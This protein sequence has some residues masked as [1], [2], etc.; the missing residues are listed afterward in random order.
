M[1][2]HEEFLNSERSAMAVVEAAK[3]KKGITSS[4]L[5][6]N[7]DIS[8]PAAS[9]ILNNLEDKGFLREAERNKAKFYTVNYKGIIEYAIKQL[10]EYSDVESLD[11]SR[12]FALLNDIYNYILENSGE[13][14]SLYDLL[15]PSAMIQLDQRLEKK[16]EQVK[17]DTA[18]TE[19]ELEKKDRRIEKLS[20]EEEKKKVIEDEREKL[21][22]ELE[23]LK[24][25]KEDMEKLK[26]AVEDY[27][28]IKDS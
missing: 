21:R 10:E 15:F 20:Q 27:L 3:A 7:H 25:E 19:E 6:A 16:I 13:G 4:Q 8:Q 17:E 1:P 11:H 22:T 24:K 2:E 23:T 18:M 14:N 9:R 12:L 26:K 28:Y 5:A